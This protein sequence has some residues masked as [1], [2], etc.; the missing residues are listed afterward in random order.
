MA[1]C[2]HYEDIVRYEGRRGIVDREWSQYPAK[3][4]V[5]LLLGFLEDGGGWVW[6][7]DT[8]VEKL[9]TVFL[10][11]PN[12]HHMPK[13]GEPLTLW[14]EIPHGFDSYLWS[15]VSWS[16]QCLYCGLPEGAEIHSQK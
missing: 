16:A 8:A 7:A 3:P 1:G 13:P 6:A 15:D 4:G 5:R 12:E 10:G 2:I 11:M 9:P 14:Q